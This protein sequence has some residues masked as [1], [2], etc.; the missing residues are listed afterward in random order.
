MKS[1][2][3]SSSKAVLSCGGGEFGYARL[4]SDRLGVL[5]YNLGSPASTEVEDVREYLKEFLLDPRVIDAP[6]L[7]RNIIVRGFILPFRPK[8]SAEAYRSIWTDEGSPLIVTSRRQ[9]ELLAEG[10][11]LPVYLCMRYGEPS[12]PKVVADIAK[13]GVTHLLILPL[14]PHYSMASYETGLVAIEEAI[15]QQCPGLSYQAVAPYYN[16]PEYIE[17]LAT[18]LRPHVETAD[19]FDHLLLSYHGIPERHL[20][21]SDPS[22]AHCL[23]CERCCDL[24]NPAHA[25]CYR[26]QCLETSRLVREKLKVPEEK[27]SVSFQSRLGRDPWLQPYTDKTLEALPE[28]GKKKLVIACPAF[29]T[30]CLETIEEIGEE[31]KETFME[32][33]GE[34][35]TMVPCLND[36]PQW[37][38]YLA[39]RVGKWRQAPQTVSRNAQMKFFYESS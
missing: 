36:H 25:T 13:D 28:K 27:F 32:A 35:F 21:K 1:H 15:Q 39:D 20:R 16:D 26:H 3:C 14:Y 10:T 6:A 12:T 22:H 11:G 33:G 9:Q 4:V 30:D 37:I 5:L 2:P 19:G 31:G 34:A 24:P 18:T 38:T 17:C 29:V 8:N 7:I 23:S